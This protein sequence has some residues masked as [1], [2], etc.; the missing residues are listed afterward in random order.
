MKAIV[1]PDEWAVLQ[2]L[3]ATPGNVLEKCL[4]LDFLMRLSDGNMKRT[5]MILQAAEQSIQKTRKSTSFAEACNIA[6]AE[7][8]DCRA[9]TRCDFRYYSN[10]LIARNPTLGTSRMCA[11]T[12]ADC[13][14]YLEHAFE[15]PQQLRKGR[16]VM[17]AIFTT[18][19]RRGWCAKNVVTSV[20]VPRVKEHYIPI[21]S[22]DEIRILLDVVRRYKDGICAPAVGIMLYAGV[23][24][25]EVTRLCWEHIDW[26]N[27][28]LL[29][30]PQHSKTGGARSIP[31]RK[32]LLLMLRDF[33]NRDGRLKI[34][35]PCWA[36]HWRTIHQLSGWGHDTPWRPDVLRHTFASYH[37]QHYKDFH[38]LQWEM[39]HHDLSL[40]RTRY[41]DLSK[42]GDTVA[43]WMEDSP[44]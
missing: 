29:V 12:T 21:L 43:F 39:G 34:C 31:L 28:R 14:C 4:L 42:V 7:R 33:R 15:T 16:A 22:E 37:L 35:P 36:K 38:A 19:C 9:R 26:H 44:K 18:A 6:L 32:P 40:L 2:I 25:H 20:V 1:T 30:L 11:I 23:R 41:V 17:S 27:A 13:Q 8:A 10:R 24:P 3:R 5:Y